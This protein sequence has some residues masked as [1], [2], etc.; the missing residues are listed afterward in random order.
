[1]G[2]E[3]DGGAV[4]LAAGVTGGDGRLGVLRE[5]HRAQRRQLL[6]ARIGPWVLVGV[7]DRRRGAALARQLDRHD[8]LGE[9]AALLRGDRELVRAERQFVLLL[10]RDRVLA[11]QVLGRLE[12]PAGDRMVDAAGGDAPGGEAVLE[13]ALPARAPQ[14]TFV[15]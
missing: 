3:A 1:M 5:H 2:D 13:L 8:L 12:H 7:D 15:E 10:A 6:E 9:R 14:R 11:P 4:V